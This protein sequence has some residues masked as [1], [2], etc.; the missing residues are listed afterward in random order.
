VHSGRSKEE[1]PPFGIHPLVQIPV[2]SGVFAST[3]SRISSLSHPDTILTVRLRIGFVS[4]SKIEISANGNKE[5][6]WP[7]VY[8]K[9]VLRSETTGSWFHPEADGDAVDDIVGE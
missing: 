5:A 7:S 9:D 2:N 1:Y 4:L 6:F 3:D 8:T